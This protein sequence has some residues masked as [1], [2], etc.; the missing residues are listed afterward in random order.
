MLWEGEVLQMIQELKQA[1]PKV[2]DSDKAWKQINYFTNNQE[3]MDYPRY[4]AAGWP[5]GSGLDEG[6]C[7]L[8]V[9]RRFKGNGMRW[10]PHDNH[11][12]LRTRLALLN[13]DLK[14]YF[15][16]PEECEVIAA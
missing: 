9:G 7:K 13:G 4:R 15:S 5:I 3:R 12:V 11:C 6:Q 2:T 8:V 10:R 1:L 14:S 16:P